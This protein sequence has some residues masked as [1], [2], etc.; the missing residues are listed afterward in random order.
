MTYQ[1]A[2]TY[3]Y[4]S[5][6]AFHLVGADAYKPGLQNVKALMARFGNPHTR[7]PSIHVAGT[8]G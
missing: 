6:P 5:A 1:D 7:F 4:S 3:L 8:N 2:L